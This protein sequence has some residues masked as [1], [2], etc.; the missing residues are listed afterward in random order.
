MDG[1]RGYVTT[2]KMGTVNGDHGGPT[3]AE[4]EVPLM[5]GFA[6]EKSFITEAVKTVTH[7]W[8]SGGHEGQPLRHYHMTKILEEIARQLKPPP[9]TEP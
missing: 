2:L 5:F 1:Q 6:G 4:S 8:N 7:W 3:R 9:E